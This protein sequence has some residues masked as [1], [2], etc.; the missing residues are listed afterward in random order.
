MKRKIFVSF[1]VLTSVILLAS[2]GTKYESVTDNN[3]NTFSIK[4]DSNGFAQTDEKGN[5]IVYETDKNGKIKQT[6]DGKDSSETID[7]PNYIKSESVVECESFYIEIP[8]GWQVQTGHTIKLFNE[9]NQA[10]IAFTLRTT[11]TTDECLAQIKDLFSGWDADW[12]ESEQKFS[13]GQAKVISST[14]LIDHYEKSYYVFAVKGNSY[15]ISTSFNTKLADS[16][17]FNSIIGDIKFK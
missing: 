1:L 9:E 3:G 10:E 17:D 6:D 5:L 13:F 14:K 16:V 8:D 11:D 15:A 4:R 7:F 2:C 12:K